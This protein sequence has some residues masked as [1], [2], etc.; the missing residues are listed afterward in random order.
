MC[1]A[2]QPGYRRFQNNLLK[3]LILYQGD[4]LGAALPR[5]LVAVSNGALDYQE[6]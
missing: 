3:C 2:L 4:N 5:S 1:K 6:K